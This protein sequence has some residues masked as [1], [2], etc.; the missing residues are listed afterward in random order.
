[1][2]SALINSKKSL[3]SFKNGDIKNSFFDAVT[4]A[5]MFKLTEEKNISRE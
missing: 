5:L 2:V 4:Y 3:V 1:M